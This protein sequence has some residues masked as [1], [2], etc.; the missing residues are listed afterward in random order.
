MPSTVFNKSP[1]KNEILIPKL[2]NAI[3]NQSKYNYISIK[4]LL[5][6]KKIFL[7][8]QITLL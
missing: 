5:E 4:N 3:K 8:I 6:R 2:P 7:N 1:R